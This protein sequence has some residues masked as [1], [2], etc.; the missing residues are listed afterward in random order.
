MAYW[1]LKTEPN[2]YSFQD[3][4]QDKTTE[5]DGVRNYQARN[6]LNSMKT[7][8][9]C[10]IYHSGKERAVVGFAKV[11]K[12]AYPDPK[13][14]DPRWVNVDIQVQAAVKTPVTLA[15]MKAEKALAEM[16]LIRQ[17]RLSVCPMT[18]AEWQLVSKLA[19]RA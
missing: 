11:I 1:L 12:A 7:G 17:S 18:R 19:K 9:S 13:A 5:W 14:D 2:T 6:H 10:M 15:E 4:E 8:D 3:L 16:T